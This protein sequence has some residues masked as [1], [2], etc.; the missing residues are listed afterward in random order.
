MKAGVDLKRV[1]YLFLN[2]R[3]QENYN[4]MKHC[5]KLADFGFVCMRLFDDW[6]R[7]DMIACHIDGQQLLRIQ[8]K[9]RLTFDK[10]Y[11]GKDLWIAFRPGEHDWYLYPHDEALELVLADNRLAGT[12]SWDVH[13]GYNWPGVPAKLRT[14]LAHYH[15]P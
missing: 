15:I 6:Q 12:I 4:C 2:A 9:A 11:Q 1:D 8:L 7:A 3:Q 14:L 13:G 10:K 5:G